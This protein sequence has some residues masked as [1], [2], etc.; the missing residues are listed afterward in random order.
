MAITRDTLVR[1]LQDSLA[2]EID[3]IDDSTALFSGGLL[4]SFSVGELLVF[5]EENGGFQIEPEE[6]VVENIDS[7]NQILRFVQDKCRASVG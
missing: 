6:V 7:I 3:S 2:L 5:L 4:D 1:F